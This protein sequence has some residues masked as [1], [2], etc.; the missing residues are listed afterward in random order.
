[1]LQCSIVLV[2]SRQ[3]TSSAT[4]FSRHQDRR[5]APHLVGMQVEQERFLVRPSM[6]GGAD[7]ADP[8]HLTRVVCTYQY[9][10]PRS[11]WSR[12]HSVSA[13]H[14]ACPPELGVQIAECAPR[15]AEN[16]LQHPGLMSCRCRGRRLS[17]YSGRLAACPSTAAQCS[18]PCKLLRVAD[19]GC[20]C[21]ETL[22]SCRSVRTGILQPVFIITGH[23]SC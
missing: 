1:M 13:H 15:V 5:R 6:L 7:D 23:N 18:P 3:R 9:P 4:L 8:G 19:T 22:H 17:G 20:S 11:E 10:N 16:T 2:H 21:P 12:I 14:M